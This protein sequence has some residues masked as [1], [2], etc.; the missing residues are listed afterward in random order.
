MQENKPV[1]VVGLGNPGTQ[2]ARTRHN[3]GFMAVDHLAGADAVWKKEKN[4]LT[5]SLTLAG[6]RVILVKPQTYMNNSGMAVGPLMAFYKIPL[7]NLIVIHDDLDLSVG[8]IRRKMGGGS[9]GHNG[10]KSIDAAVGPNY[11]RIRIGI[12]HPRTLGLPMS[13]ADWVLG[14][15]DDT[16]IA[17]INAAIE[18][19]DLFG[20]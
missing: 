16:Q 14:R 9:A 2:Y 12:D 18:N 10:I 17:A 11:H 19:L 1:L 13:P 4:A 15:F 8:A 20:G 3:V 5:T 6:H 7:D